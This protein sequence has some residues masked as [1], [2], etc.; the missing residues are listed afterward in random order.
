M[1]VRYCMIVIS[2]IDVRCL[3]LVGV[4]VQMESDTHVAFKEIVGKTV[5]LR[6]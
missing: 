6:V 2:S 1:Y 3:C 5:L 4:C